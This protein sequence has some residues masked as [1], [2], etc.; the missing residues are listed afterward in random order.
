M[1]RHLALTLV[2]FIISVGLHAYL[3]LH[4][5][6]RGIVEPWSMVWWKYQLL[7][8]FNGLSAVLPGALVGFVAGRHGLLL[9]A[10]VGFL[11]H[12]GGVVAW[13]GPAQ[14]A[15]LT[16]YA[17]SYSAVSALGHTVLSAAGGAAGQVLRSNKSLERT[18][19]R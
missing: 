5:G 2:V 15:S 14:E 18:R 19:D 8:L 12:I 6:I 3:N 10:L 7:P 9:G 4:L 16:L 11:G 1:S 13:S 17:L